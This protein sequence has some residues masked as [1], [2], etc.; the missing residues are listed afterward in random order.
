MLEAEIFGYRRGAF[1]GADRDHAGYVTLADDG[2][3]FL[4]EVGDLPAECQT[5]LLRLIEAKSYRP[6]G[7]TYD[8]RADVK[9]IAAT[10]KDLAAEAKAGKFRADLL[11]AFRAEILV[12]PLRS[13]AEDIRHLAQYFLDRISAEYRR[14][15]LLTPQ[16]IHFLC[17]RSWPGNVRQ[18]RSVLA[19]AAAAV[20]GDD[21]TDTDLQV[22][23][24][25][26]AATEA[27]ID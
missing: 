25:D 9:V 15:W 14:E 20:S 5:R 12:P 11:N 26:S 3:L 10:R 8:N 19:H 13:H 1:S 24:G 4:D 27:A 22:L 18:L 6:I 23:L 2:T 21:I 17:H 16:A 7:A